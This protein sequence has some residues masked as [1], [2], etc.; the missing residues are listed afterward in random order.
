MTQPIFDPQ[1]WKGRLA[2]AVDRE[3]VRAAVFDCSE[4]KWDA[5]NRQH[6]AIIWKHI[7]KNDSVLDVGCGWG[8]LLYLMPMTW[9]GAY[10]GVDLSPDFLAVARSAHPEREFVQLDLRE[11]F[12]M[13]ITFDW[14]IL[15][16]VREM[17]IREAGH[18]VW[19]GIKGN[20]SRCCRRL[21]CLEYDENDEGLVI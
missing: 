8:R 16:S 19:Q 1:F 6:R 14:G 17:V 13:P 20:V 10:V 5:I 21:L 18:K 3:M 4:V 7:G 11:P 9:K 15:V 12:S 2:K